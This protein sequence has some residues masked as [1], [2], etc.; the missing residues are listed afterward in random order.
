MGGETERKHDIGGEIERRLGHEKERKEAMG[1]EIEEAGH[2]R[3][4]WLARLM[5]ERRVRESW[6]AGGYSQY[7]CRVEGRETIEWE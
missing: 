3:V 5:G 7:P 1:G 2:G 6:A 4:V